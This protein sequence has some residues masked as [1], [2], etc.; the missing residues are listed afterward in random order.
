MQAFFYVVFRRVAC[1]TGTLI[2]VGV[3]NLFRETPTSFLKAMRGWTK[4]ALSTL[5]MDSNP[6]LFPKS[7]YY[8]CDEWKL[9]AEIASKWIRLECDEE[10]REFIQQ[11]KERVRIVTSL[12]CVIL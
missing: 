10:S 8:A 4:H 3:L 9:S 1:T 6:A 11:C 5:K 12:S 2:S 7:S